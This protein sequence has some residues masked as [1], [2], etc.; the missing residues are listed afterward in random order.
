MKKDVFRDYNEY[1]DRGMMKWGAFMLSEH[2]LRKEKDDAL[3]AKT[4]LPKPVMSYSEIMEMAEIAI[5][6]NKSVAVQLEATDRNGHY[7]PD[8][9]GMIRGE[10]DSI[11]M[12]GETPVEIDAIRHILLLDVENYWRF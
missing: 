10:E 1:H 12:V 11:L 5:R 3:R 2:S 8:V 6:K 9:T 4:Y 7:L